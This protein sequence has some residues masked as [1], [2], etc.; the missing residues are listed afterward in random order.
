MEEG[1][2]FTFVT[3][4]EKVFDISHKGLKGCKLTANADLLKQLHNLL[5][6]ADLKLTL[7]WMPSHLNDYDV[8]EPG[9]SRTDVL[10]N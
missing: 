8:L 1:S 10:G 4:N 3:D 9:I 5:A 7:R 6:L 2:E